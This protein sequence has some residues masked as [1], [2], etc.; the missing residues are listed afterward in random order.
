VNRYFLLRD[1][2]STN[3]TSLD[4]VRIEPEKSYQLRQDSIIGLGIA[5]D[6][7]ACA[8][9]RFKESP[10]TETT[11]VPESED[12]AH[13]SWLR[14]DLEKDEIYVDG[15]Q[16]I[17]SK[18]EYDLMLCLKANASKV[19]SKDEIIARVWP[20]AVDAS[21][22]SD[23]AIDQLL[24]RLRLKIEPDPANPQRLISRRGFGYMLV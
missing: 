19:C 24:H 3:G 23:A 2:K 15:K 20:E 6:G 9:L 21:G 16:V 22:V 14:I 11:R 18:K 10:T 8:V 12:T 17:V 5:T 1:L 4:G 7:E 13:A